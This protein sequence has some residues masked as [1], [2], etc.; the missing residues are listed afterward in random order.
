MSNSDS[1][2]EL[3]AMD[4]QA[5]SGGA[6]SE[7]TGVIAHQGLREMLRRDE[8]VASTEFEPDQLQPASIDLRLGRRAWRVRASFL[9]GT[10]NTVR[11]R[12][13]KLGGIEIDLSHD[14]VLESGVVYVVELVES[15][16]LTN[17]VWGI[18]NPK[19]STGRLD[20]LVRLITN[21]ATQFDIVRKRYEGPLYLEIAPQAFSIVVRRGVRLNQHRF[22]RGTAPGVR[23]G[24]V[25]G[26]TELYKSGQLVSP[27]GELLPL[28]GE[29]VPVSIDL[30]GAGPQSI[31]GY[32][33]KT[34]TDAIDVSR[35]AYYNPRDFW[36]EIRDVD[37]RL[38]LDKGQFYILATREDVGVPPHLAAEMV[39]FDPSSG[40][41]R[42][43]YAGFFDPGFG[44]E[45]G[46]AQGSKAVLE[47]RSYGVSFMLENGQIVGW[48]N[49]C[50]LVGGAPD[51][52]Y[53]ATIRSHYQ[54]QGVAL[55]KQFLRRT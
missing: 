20:I 23:I 39:P 44:Y 34:T 28:R 55:A 15:V 53:G 11:E 45:E 22:M 3:F 31:V 47:V 2:S 49:Y 42:V 5:S 25:G 29:H 30:R 50:R 9:P 6:Y 41:F 36:E 18:A 13:E 4:D 7:G 12:I 33:A 52:L 8:V 21:E 19:S 24:S 37:G 27:D 17:G 54:G 51:K 10:G 14:T 35:I 48:L 16:K 1:F 40:E 38:S 43:H 46:R 26:L 32:K